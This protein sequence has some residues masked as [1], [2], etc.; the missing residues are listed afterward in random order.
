MSG[1]EPTTRR[2]SNPARSS[3]VW[4]AHQQRA[5]IFALPFCAFSAITPFAAF[6][7]RR[8]HS[9]HQIGQ[10]LFGVAVKHFAIW[11]KEERV[12]Q[13]GKT[14]PLSSL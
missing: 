2:G 11:L 4:M 9:L 8:V 14:F 13:P 3:D 12:N 7:S 6:Q 5:E 1:T 10:R